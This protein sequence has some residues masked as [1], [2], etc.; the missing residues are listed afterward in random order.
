MQKGVYTS[1][2]WLSIL[3]VVL[4]NLQASGLFEPTHW[5]MKIAAL[6]LSILTAL[7]YTAKRTTLKL[8]AAQ[9]Q[10]VPAIENPPTP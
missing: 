7:G 6:G 4:M 9:S 10:A 8:S 5:P 2:F 1:E 3:V